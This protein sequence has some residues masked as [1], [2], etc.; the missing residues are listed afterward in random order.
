MSHG[1][2]GPDVDCASLAGASIGS[3]EQTA[4]APGVKNVDVA[5]IRRDV[6][7]LATADRIH[8]VSGAV[9]RHA[10]G[11]VVLLRATDVIRHVCRGEYAVQLRGRKVLI[12]P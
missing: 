5:R 7:A 1:V 6:A 3:G 9:T 8:D 11:A 10:H 2:I 4:V 12:R